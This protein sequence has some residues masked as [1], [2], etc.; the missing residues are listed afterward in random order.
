MPKHKEREN[1][2]TIRFNGNAAFCSSPLIS[3]QLSDIM[4]LS[5]RF[6]SAEEPRLTGKEKLKFFLAVHWRGICCV[7]IPVL[8]LPILLPPPTEAYHWCAFTLVIMA[9]F[10]VTECIPLAVTSFLPIIIFPL[11]GITS[12]TATCSAY[13]SDSLMMFLGSLILAACVEQSGLHVRLA[14]FAIRTIGFTH[15]RLLLSMSLVTMFVSM[16]LTNTAAVTMMVPINFAVLKVFEEQK[17]M[18]IFEYTADG[19]RVASDITTC[20]FCAATYSATI[21]GLGT[22]IGTAT[23]LVMKGLL[24]KSFPLVPEYLSFPQFSAFSIPMMICLEATMLLSLCVVFLGWLRPKSTAAKRS[25]VTPQGQAAAKA[26]VDAS[27]KELGSITFWEYMVILLFGGS[28]VLFFCRSPQMFPGWGDI[29]EDIFDRPHKF[30]KDSALACLVGFLMFVSPSNLS[31]FKNFTVKYY[32]QLP[33]KPVTSV[34]DWKKMDAS[35]PY[36]FMFLLGKL[37]NNICQV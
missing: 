10:W 13:I 8:A 28:M 30:I 12:T 32:E 3:A 22:I 1:R 14:Y 20:Y 11:T 23:N 24:V 34:L 7:A 25:Y 29:L 6:G 9:C 19:E 35:L 15:I 33:K 36:S 17:L 2:R 16:W 18:T 26:V 31:F 5:I 27:W 4:N 21:G 37:V